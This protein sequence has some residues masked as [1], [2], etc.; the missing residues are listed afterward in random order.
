MKRWIKKI[1]PKKIL[2]HYRDQ[3]AEKRKLEFEKSIK[4]DNVLCPICNSTFST[5]GNFGLIERSNAFCYNC[6]SLERH[7]LLFLYLKENTDLFS[8]HERPV[9]LLHFAPE[10]AFFDFFSKI[11]GLEYYPCDIF[12]EKYNFDLKIKVYKVD[13]TNIPFDDNY[14]DY[15]LCNHVLEHIPDDTLAM[16]ELYR[17][18]S[19]KGS[20]IFQVPIDY[21]RQT[22]YEDW[23][24]TTPEEREKAFGQNDHVRWYGRDYNRRLEKTGFILDE[25]DFVSKFSIDNIFKYGLDKTETIYL[26]RKINNL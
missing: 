5:F 25:I 10:K 4:G 20:G 12:P 23:S 24:I 22:T 1:L 2:Q 17:V 9:R 16:S 13:I 6:E 3:K 18:M 11:S 21:T 7:R 14:F 19:K 8:E 26:C 15:I